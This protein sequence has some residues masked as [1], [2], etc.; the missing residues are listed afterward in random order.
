MKIEPKRKASKVQ[1][2]DRLMNRLAF[3]FLLP[4]LKV[5]LVFVFDASLCANQVQD[6]SVHQPS[7]RLPFPNRENKDDIQPERAKEPM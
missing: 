1:T 7:S 6:L 5:T 4:I 3:C 2:E